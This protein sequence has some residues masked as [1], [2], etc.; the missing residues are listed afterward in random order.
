MITSCAV[1]AAEL[2]VSADACVQVGMM[3]QTIAWTS[4]AGVGN[5]EKCWFKVKLIGPKA[6]SC[7]LGPTSKFPR[8]NRAARD[9]GCS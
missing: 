8:A 5:T 1:A 4:R 2:D 6:I 9:E 3:V 7:L